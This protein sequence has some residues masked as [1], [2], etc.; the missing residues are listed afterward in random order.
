MSRN[1]EEKLLQKIISEK[2]PRNYDLVYN[3]TWKMWEL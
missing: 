3:I 2:Y 1:Y